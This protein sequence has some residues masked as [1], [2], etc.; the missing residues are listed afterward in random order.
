MPPVLTAAL[1]ICGAL[2]LLLILTLFLFLGACRPQ[3]GRGDEEF[4]R[5]TAK[6]AGEE[7]ARLMMAACRNMAAMPG[8]TLTVSGRDGAALRGRYLPCGSGGGPSPI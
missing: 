1:I 2:L 4:A 5:H 8:E 7:K 3:R 6:K